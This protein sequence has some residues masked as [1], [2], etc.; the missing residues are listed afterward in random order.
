MN[1]TRKSFGLI[2]AVAGVYAYFLLFAQFAFLERIKA[3]MGEGSALKAVLGL[4]VLGG[5]TTGFLVARKGR[6]LPW[7]TAALLVCAVVAG[8][9]SMRVPGWVFPILSFFTGA[10]MG[11]VTVALAGRIGEMSGC[12]RGCILLG[13]GTGLA[14]GFC[15]IP[16]VFTASPSAQCVMSAIV[17]LVAL[18]G[19]RLMGEGEAP[20]GAP[21]I[22]WR[23][24][25]IFAALVWMDAAVFYV[26]QHAPELKAGTWR[27]EVLWR[28]AGIHLVTAV[29]AGYWL[30]FGGLRWL[31][32]AAWGMLALA[33]WW[34][35]FPDSREW[36]G[37]LYPAGV[38]LYSTALVA[39]PG[40]L[41][42][43]RPGDRMNPA[44]G[45]AA[46]LFGISGWLASGMG[47]GMAESLHRVPGRFL[48]IAGIAVVAG[49]FGKRFDLRTIIPV[50]LVALGAGFTGASSRSAATAM[51]RGHDLYV[52]EGCIHCHSRYVRPGSSDELIWGRAADPA[53]ILTG[54]PVLIGNRR[55]G[56]DLLHVG[57][58]RSANWLRE[59][60]RDPRMFSPD[61]PM[62]S[63]ASLVADGRADDL[64]AWLTK[65]APAEMARTWEVAIAWKPA[66]ILAGDPVRG[67][68]LFT[69]SCTAC[70]GV[71]AHGD[72]PLAK[73]LQSPPRNLVTGPF[74]L[75]A[76][77]PDEP[78]IVSVMRV[79]RFGIPG[80]D[81]PGHETWSAQE[82]ADISE[83]LL[84]Q[85]RS[86]AR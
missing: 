28:N 51:A 25:L 75:S 5:V 42:G 53:E 55:Q 20:I 30:S 63:Y 18:T 39:W 83:W 31:W 3:V 43:E 8:V 76:A 9:A 44:M 85:R 23:A 80:T 78:P 14:Y 81:M 65:D 17:A 46:W 6:P 74:G 47:I 37:W 67:H 70:H 27:N 24:I 71:D 41:A 72:G 48:A 10:A 52:S 59:H 49:A 15:N 54:Q 12:R 69:A 16:A 1:T 26:I 68:A 19:G 29:I 56:P 13:W 82:L 22:P 58:R 35:N 84:Q 7:L 4:M 40:L 21:S 45:R 66:E 60:F 61:S 64:I 32:L 34:V 86:P 50:G 79:V 33:G 73:G 77:R 57:G 2:L 38:S 36:A 11:A 62:P